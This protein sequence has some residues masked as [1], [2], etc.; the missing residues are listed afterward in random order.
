MIPPLPVLPLLGLAGMLGVPSGPPAEEGGSG[1][2]SETVATWAAPPGPAPTGPL[3]VAGDPSPTETRPLSTSGQD[4]LPDTIPEGPPAGADPESTEE[5]PEAQDRPGAHVRSWGTMAAFTLA[6]PSGFAQDPEDRSGLS[7]ITA[8]A[9]EEEGN[10]RLRSFLSEI[11]VTV[12]QEETLVT[13]V[14][15]RET[16]R[17]ALDRLEGLLFRHPLPQSAFQ[18]ARNRVLERVAFEEGAPVRDFEQEKWQLLAGPTHPWAR[19]PQGRREGVMEA[20][21]EELNEH[22][23][24]LFSRELVEGAAVGPFEPEEL[25]SWFSRAR[26]VDNGD[27]GS[28]PASGSRPW[29]G[30][31]RRVVDREVTS[32]WIVF[33]YP[34]PGDMS[35]TMLELMAHILTERLTPSPPDPGLFSV[36]VGPR[37]VPD[38]TALVLQLTVDP[39]RTDRWEEQV[40]QLVSSL[41][42]EAETEEFFHQRRRRFRSALLHELAEPEAHAR[43]M[44]RELMVHGTVS[45]PE[46]EIWTHS[47]EGVRDAARELGE[48]RVLLFGPA[49]MFEGGDR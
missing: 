20:T 3:R 48:P 41:A 12:E 5:E 27:L 42:D 14:A 30:G 8:R 7:W 15:P 38:G 29:D 21:M 2:E 23:A 39:R 45:D 10:R 22:R 25:P 40:R 16:W 32:T 35:W 4:A 24:R 1:V 17:E 34:A 13:L 19:P 11:T 6:F 44:A 43:R 18:T 9:L 26:R 49:S 31:E 37:T 33:A 46:E 47:A 28:G 36:E